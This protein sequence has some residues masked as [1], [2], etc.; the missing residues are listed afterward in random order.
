TKFPCGGSFAHAPG[1]GQWTRRYVPPAGR[2]VGCGMRGGAQRA[3]GVYP[4]GGNTVGQTRNPAFAVASSARAPRGSSPQLL[5]GA[6]SRRGLS[7]WQSTVPATDVHS[8]RM[9][10]LYV[11]PAGRDVERGVAFRGRDRAARRVRATQGAAG[12]IP[13]ADIR[14]AARGIPRSP[15]RRPRE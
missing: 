11:P 14:P 9:D 15:L 3:G 8:G 5:D 6:R 1:N 10:V 12:F 2:Y 7:I 13:P 4:P